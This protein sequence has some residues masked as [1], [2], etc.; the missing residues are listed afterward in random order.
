MRV[1]L[2]FATPAKQIVKEIDVVDGA[3]VGDVIEQAGLDR[4]FPEID[5][6]KLQTGVWGRLAERGQRVRDGDRVEL[7]RPLEM[8]PREARRLKAGI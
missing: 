4:E 3:T 6:A 2:A 7:Y 1:E 5:F 8:D